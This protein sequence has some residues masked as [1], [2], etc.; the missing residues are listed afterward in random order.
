VPLECQS[1][2]ARCDFRRRRDSLCDNFVGSLRVD[3][4]TL[5]FFASKT[6]TW[7]ADDEDYSVNGARRNNPLASLTGNFGDYV[8]VAVVVKHSETG[9]LCCSGNQEIRNFPSTL[10]S[11]CQ[12]SLHL[13]SATKVIRYRLY[14][15]KYRQI[16]LSIIPFA[17][18]TTAVTHLEIRNPR[19]AYS[20]SRHQR[21]NN[22]ADGGRPES[23][24]DTR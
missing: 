7:S 18:V 1:V 17:R 5:R 4:A 12:Q 3:V 6:S 10:T 14:Q 8:V 11:R 15:F 16:V 9:L 13:P 23:K 19:S 2:L 22:C 21:L 20:T 24:D